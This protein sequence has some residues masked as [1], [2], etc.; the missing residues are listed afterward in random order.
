M[1]LIKLAFLAISLAI[2][3]FSLSVESDNKAGSHLS[4]VQYDESH[5]DID[6]A[7]IGVSKAS[8]FRHSLQQPVWI[9]FSI[10][11]DFLISKT[12]N[13]NYFSEPIDVHWFET[14]TFP[15]Y[16][17]SRWKH[18]NSQYRLLAIAG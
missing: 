3:L 14:I 7:F 11:N 18:S 15:D 4:V 10:V 5:T 6:K 17:P 2:F 8:Y 1:R 16:R 12:A 9:S 13:Q